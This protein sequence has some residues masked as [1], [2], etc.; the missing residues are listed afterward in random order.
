MKPR[1]MNM[2]TTKDMR[3]RSTFLLSRCALANKDINMNINEQIDTIN[4]LIRISWF[5]VVVDTLL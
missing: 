1:D 2:V 5:H 4:V 3:T